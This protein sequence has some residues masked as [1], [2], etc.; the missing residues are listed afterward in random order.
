M[1]ILLDSG[2]DAYCAP[3]SFNPNTRISPGGVQL[4]DAQGNV[5]SG[6]G[7][8]EVD[9]HVDGGWGSGGKGNIV[10]EALFHVANVTQPILSF[11]KL[12]SNGWIPVLNQLGGHL[13]KEECK[14]SVKVIRS[15]LA[16]EAWSGT[17]TTTRTSQQQHQQQDQVQQRYHWL[18][19]TLRK[20]ISKVWLWKAVI[21][22]IQEQMSQQ[23]LK[24]V[25]E[26]STEEGQNFQR[27]VQAL[28]CV[29]D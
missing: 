24:R 21:I 10:A 11:V 29:S 18:Q 14:V 25:A 8:K 12:L 26:A 27:A 6:G 20:R 16:I 2:S 19:L 4:R 3:S 5:I 13:I 7:V 15:S 23:L 9:F 17:L 1:T 22:I 28:R